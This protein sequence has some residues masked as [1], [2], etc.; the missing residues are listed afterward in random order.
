MMQDVIEVESEDDPLRT[1]VA[2]H[3]I[4]LRALSMTHSLDTRSMMMISMS[5]SAIVSSKR[6]PRA[7]RIDDL[8]PKEVCR[9]W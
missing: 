7:N 8:Q 6:Y 5:I 1:F 3:V 2:C 9:R 4:R